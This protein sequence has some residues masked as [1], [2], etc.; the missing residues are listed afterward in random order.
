[1]TYTHYQFSKY[2]QTGDALTV[3]G[4]NAVYQFAYG[5]GLEI[6]TSERQRLAYSSIS[7][8][9]E[10]DLKIEEE[11][12]QIE[13]LLEAGAVRLAPEE[14]G[15][16]TPA[17]GPVLVEVPT[18]V[19]NYHSFYGCVKVQNFPGQYPQ[20]VFLVDDS[21]RETYD[22]LKVDHPVLLKSGVYNNQHQLW[23]FV[24]NL[25]LL[26]GIAGDIEPFAGPYGVTTEF[27]PFA[28]PYLI[29]T[30][31][32]GY[33]PDMEDFTLERVGSVDNGWYSTVPVKAGRAL[34]SGETLSAFLVNRR[35]GEITRFGFTAQDNESNPSQWPQAFAKH[36]ANQEAGITAGRWAED[37]SFSTTEAP[38]RLWSHAQYRAFSNAPFASNLVQALACNDSFQLAAEQTLCLQVRDLK[39]QALFEQHFFT[40]SK[41]QVAAQ[42]SKHLCKQIIRDSQ[43]LRAGVLN[44][45]SNVIPA[46]TGNAFWA[47]QCAELSVTLTVST[48][49]EA[50]KVDGAL[51]LPAGT[52]LHA[53]VYDAFSQRMLGHHEWTPTS[54]QRASGQWLA[55]WATA[56]NASDVSAYLRA[57]ATRPDSDGLII[58]DTSDLGLWHRG[59]AL[60]IFTSLSDAGNRMPGPALELPAGVTS[61]A[62]VQVTL[63]HAINGKP[64]HNAVF[65]PAQDKEGATLD[66]YTW[67][68]ALAQFVNDKAWP[69]LQM[70]A[71]STTAAEMQL[72]MPR[73]SELEVE[74]ECLSEEESVTDDAE[75]ATGATPIV[76]LASVGGSLQVTVDSLA[77]ELEFRMAK[78]AFDKGY[79][80]A[81]CVPTAK[82]EDAIWPESVTANRITW[83]GPIRQ[84]TYQ[85]TLSHPDSIRGEGEESV[86]HIGAFDQTRFWHAPQEVKYTPS[87]ALAPYQPSSH[88]CEDYGSTEQSELFDTLGQT[89]TGVDQ[90]TGLFHAHYPVAT[91]QGL[92]GLGPLCD[93]TLHYSALRGNEAGLGDG[94]AW[95]FSSLDVRERRLTLANGVRVT[96]TELEWEQLGKGQALQKETVRVHCTA[97]FSTFTIDMPTGRREILSQPADSDD[98]EPNDEFRQKVIAALEAIKEKHQPKFPWLPVHGEHWTQWVLWRIWPVG[99][100]GSAVLDYTK[101]RNAWAKHGKTKHLDERIA[102]YKRPFVQL[103]PSRIESAYGEALDLRWKRLQGQFQLICIKSA[104]EALFTAEYSSPDSPDAEVKMQIWPQSDEAY[105]VKLQLNQHLLRTL[106]REQSGVIVQQVDCGYDD[107]PT[108][109]RVLCR[110]QERDGSVEYVKYRPGIRLEQDRPLW[111]RVVLHALVPGDG[112]ENQINTLRYKGRL[113]N[114]NHALYIVAGERGAHGVRER[115]LQVFGRDANS[116][117]QELIVGSASA[118]RQCI[119]FKAQNKKTT[120][121][122]RYTGFGDDLVKAIEQIKVAID[123][124]G[125]AVLITGPRRVEHQAATLEILWNYG[126]DNHKKLISAIHTLISVTPAS[127]RQEQGKAVDILLTENND[128]GLMVKMIMQGQYTLYRAY[129]PQSGGDNAVAAQ[130]AKRLG[131]SD[132]P[133]LGCPEL[134]EYAQRPL[135]A[136]YQC[137]EFGNPKDLKLF[138]YSVLER[139]GRNML[140]PAQQ[141]VIEGVAVAGEFNG[142]F[143]D[144]TRWVQDGEGDVL[145]HQRIKSVSAINP[146]KT[147]SGASKVRV[148][149]S[150]DTQLSHLGTE[151]F[152][153]ENIQWFNDNPNEPYITVRTTCETLAGTQLI[154]EEQCSRYSQRCLWRVERDTETY[155]AYDAAGRVVEQTQYRLKSGQQRHTD[156]QKADVHICTHYS[157]DGKVATHTQ[158]NKEQ[159]RTYLDGF[160]RVWRTERQLAGTAAAV[161]WF[162]MCFAGLND[163]H[164]LGRY[165]WDYLPGGQAVVERAQVQ[166][167][168]RP[169]L[170]VKERGEVVKGESSAAETLR[171]EDEEDVREI[172][173]QGFGAANSVS[174]AQFFSLLQQLYKFKNTALAQDAKKILNLMDQGF[175]L[176]LGIF[177]WGSYDP[178]KLMKLLQG[179]AGYKGGGYCEHLDD[180]WTD[181]V[182]TSVFS[183]P[184]VGSTT[185]YE[186]RDVECSVLINGE[187]RA[188]LTLPQLSV[189][190]N[191]MKSTPD[192]DDVNVLTFFSRL[193]GVVEG[194]AP[195]LYVSS[196]SLFS[197][198]E[199]HEGTTRFTVEHG[200]AGQ[201]FTQRTLEYLTKDDGTFKR[202]ELLSNGAGQ[203]QLELIQRLDANGHVVESERI[204][205]D[206]TRTYSFE[207]DALG[208][209]TTVTRPDA[210]LIERIYHGL[211]NQVTQLKVGGKVVATQNVCNGSTLESRTVGSRTYRFDDNQDLITLPDKTRLHTRVHPSGV[212]WGAND[213]TVASLTRK[214]SVTTVAAGSNA[215]DAWGQSF[216]QGSLPGR[217]QSTQTTPHSVVRSVEWQTLRGTTV[218]CLRADGHWQRGFTDND[219]RL[220]R[221]CQDH[222]DVAYR[223]DALGQL[224]SRKVHA[225]QP[226]EQWQVFSEHNGLGQ[227]TRR[228]FLHNGAACFEQRMTWQGDGRLASKISYENNQLQ[229][230]ERFSYDL[231]DR[232]QRYTCDTDN[233]LHCPIDAEG[234]VVKE[235][236]FTWD[237]LDNLVSCVTTCFD[238]TTKRRAFTYDAGTDP[239]QMTSVQRGSEAVALSWSDNGYLQND[240]QGRKFGYNIC[241]QINRVSDAS[242]GL[243]S[244]YQYDGYQRLAAQ[245][246]KQDESTRELRYD[247][248]ELIGEVWFDNG[249]KVTRRTSISA[250]LAEYDGEQVRWL[251]DDVQVGVAGQVQGGELSLAPRLP[252]G[253]GALLAEVVSGY[254]GMRC[255]PVTGHYHAG[256]GKRS[257]AP[258]LCRYAQPDWLAP[259][260]EGGHNPYQH[261]PDPVNLHDPSG[262]IML[263]RWGQGHEL[264]DL[265]KDLQQ[266]QSMVAGTTWRGLAMSFALTVV[267][268]G[269]S[270]V[271]AGTASMWVFRLL[272][273]ISASSFTMEVVSELVVES[274]PKLAR[275][276][277]IL[278]MATGVLSIAWGG[279]KMAG[280][281]LK[282]TIDLLGKT[283]RILGDGVKGLGRWLKRILSS[284]IARQSLWL[285]IKQSVLN[286]PANI[287]STAQKYICKANLDF[288]SAPAGPLKPMPS[289]ENSRWLGKLRSFWDGP[290]PLKLTGKPAQFYA[291]A[292]RSRFVSTIAEVEVGVLTVNTLRGT[293][294]SSIRLVN[295]DN[296]SSISPRFSGRRPVNNPYKEPAVSPRYDLWQV[297]GL[298]G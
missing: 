266:T 198:P 271:S 293:V 249:R 253:E 172:S 54:D 270:I 252:F 257:Y 9:P 46:D 152:K 288:F 179:M 184:G 287:R 230:F 267:G 241:G 56:L 8:V 90:R 32:D 22:R 197:I 258:T 61:A 53:W 129:Y 97:D 57:G 36:I 212:F 111:P 255:D 23:E 98:L 62:R 224:A 155:W 108:L 205:G 99:Y 2:F 20:F 296:T 279:V 283:S 237:A 269:A 143:T 201:C 295:D 153:L 185:R 221:T 195:G 112:Q 75:Q 91:L 220:L 189:D 161:P 238:G 240:T 19:G 118:E 166:T 243:L 114:T 117:R 30:Q 7:K 265:D 58:T 289:Y 88:L 247:G 232:L 47:P 17:S 31:P 176:A 76:T 235:Q 25:Y 85:V 138:G 268:I 87:P 218:A 140:E 263:S 69:E 106:T 134:P 147:P 72:W 121:I 10:L 168:L 156:K 18:G 105:E 103:L 242:G 15:D 204:V 42:W 272:T 73:F 24:G 228:S 126:Q 294:E 194:E 44:D 29:T 11:A 27:E 149:T 298:S 21:V 12:E 145:W 261:C 78:A 5:D 1:M 83:S 217:V 130:V 101:A 35:D 181:R 109:D 63:R 70:E 49:W 248:E 48:W 127:Q 234:N 275:T 245:F 291:W 273:A 79:R 13:A 216:S 120:Q 82:G 38:L 142:Q 284:R 39:T 102:K 180:Y 137:D 214:N 175:K 200:L 92:S 158:A 28:V 276:L 226:G 236:T 163:S 135:M 55:A 177:E 264:R 167:P 110:L 281:L 14:W 277:G 223:Y 64:L 139:A 68:V 171:I 96:F 132:V 188:G 213:N 192:E 89:E 170:W 45:D 233:A 3:D 122:I 125:E 65:T 173:Y 165:Q 182:E 4:V 104:E 290:D 77:G 144:D 81:A 94:W 67:R 244:S 100:Y 186:K 191:K 286:L 259:C 113:L 203:P 136:E 225:L 157:S 52:T 50:R 229:R 274:H 211:S 151:T 141:V 123:K 66:N 292:N 199:A 207:Y 196:S 285:S 150:K 43:L 169:Q 187:L 278:S 146:K 183:A 162:E 37:N 154:R 16:L 133:R 260:G 164:V 107:D 41:K 71:G 219:G 202:T 34:T 124:D 74:L 210:T 297:L 59:D 215:D 178:L 250:G 86:G 280:S 93:L 115:Y 128:S 190:F 208:R 95:R 116:Q 251:I 231:L 227:E 40:P 6:I 80:V 84:C 26:R 239:T 254:N 174:A 206:E 262:A 159:S 256:N 148:W 131:L 33:L 209:V 222:E 119:E 160:Q 193:T 282:G 246:V 60:R 51:D